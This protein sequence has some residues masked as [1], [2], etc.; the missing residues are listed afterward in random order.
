MD[1]RVVDLHRRF[2]AAGVD[3]GRV[4]LERIETRVVDLVV[5]DRGAPVGHPVGDQ[6]AHARAVLDPDRHGIPEAAHLLAL[7][8]RRAAV[9]GDL[10]Q[11]V[12][13][14]LLV[15]AQLA[16]DRRQLHGLL[17]R[18]HDLLHLQ[19]AL[20][21]REARF[22]LLQEVARMAQPG[23]GLLVV[24]PL[25]HAAFGGLGVAGVAHVGGVAL[26]A[27]QRPADVLAGAGEF[28]V[29]PEPEQ[30]VVDR[31]DRQVFARHLRDQPPPEAGADHHVI[32]PDRA[33]RGLDA[34]DSA[35]LDHQARGRRVGEGVEL[36]AV[37][38]LLD[39]LAGNHLGAGHDQPG[40]GVPHAAL[41]QALLDQRELLLDLGRPHQVGP[42]AEGLA[43]GDLA[44]DL[45]HPGVVA[46]PGDLEPAHLGVAPP[47]LVEVD[48]VERRP[49]GEKIVAGGVAEVRGVGGRAD[50]RRDRGL[51]D[52]DD[53]VPAPPD[54]VVGHRRPDD[55]AEANDHDLRFFGKLCHRSSP[56]RGRRAAP[57]NPCSDAKNARL[58]RLVERTRTDPRSAR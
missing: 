50:V 14:A 37:L 24:A 32:G 53:I 34:L 12:E 11:A 44:L 17:Q 2:A 39:Q 26:V 3:E 43:R 48:R 57:S 15:V 41:D 21:G 28:L 49:A 36:A 20:R 23:L 51:V 16:Q 33:A 5:V 7:T 46:D 4:G 25:D 30:R 18:L 52:A 55:A 13:G 45:F 42:G 1:R 8:H 56:Q 6:L 47:L 35:A 58:A 38:G 31:H 19:V 29:G 10:E 22:L 27:Q 40:V 54:Q 9:G